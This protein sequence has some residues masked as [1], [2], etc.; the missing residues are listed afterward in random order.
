MM[1][2]LDE[3]METFQA[4]RDAIKLARRV[5]DRRPS[6]VSNTGFYGLTPEEGHQMLDR[7]EEQLSELIAFALFA[8]FERSLRDHLSSSL[9]P[10]AASLTIPG[11]LAGRLHEFLESGVNNWRIDNVIELFN[12][13][14]S[15]Q[16]VNNAKG[17]R[18]YRHHVAHGAAPPVAIPPQIAYAQLSAFL[19]SAGLVS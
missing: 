7:A 3:H 12:P 1:N 4:A 10:L 11:E 14:V 19:K 15:D 17:I 8:T 13:P 9:G 5:L 16:D 2:P 6:P 18:T